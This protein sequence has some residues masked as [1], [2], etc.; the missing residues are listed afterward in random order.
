MVYCA[1]TRQPIDV[2]GLLRRVRR[3]ADG[4]ILTFAGV[5]RDHNEGR[6]VVQLSYA[7]YEEMAE[8]KLR[9]ICEEVG[10]QFEVGDIAAVHRVGELEI[11]DVSVA[12]SVAAP[13]RDAAYRASREIIERLKREVPI[14]KKERY[15][16]G[17]ETWQEGYPVDRRS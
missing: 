13:H 2:G 8:R 16:D 1:I 6:P 15:A 17:E 11:G 7:A 3:D 10:S 12:I 5:V 14:W 4:A 9:A